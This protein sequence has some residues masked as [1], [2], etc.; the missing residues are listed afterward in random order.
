MTDNRET[1]IVEGARLDELNGTYVPSQENKSQWKNEK[2]AVITCEITDPT[3]SGWSKYK[4]KMNYHGRTYYYIEGECNL[5]VKEG[6]KKEKWGYSNPPNGERW[7]IYDTATHTLSLEHDSLRVTRRPPRDE[8]IQNM[9]EILLRNGPINSTELKRKYGLGINV[10][11]FSQPD[12]VYNQYMEA[13]D[14][15]Q[16]YWYIE[17]QVNESNL[18]AIFPELTPEQLELARRNLRDINRL[19]QEVDTMKH[20]TGGQGGGYRKRRSKR[21]SKKK[22]KSKRSKRKNK[23]KRSKRKN[24][25][26][27]RK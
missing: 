26:R 19:I 17:S 7:S 9:L 1:L 10:D 12:T 18:D 4:W 2:G 21:T 6:E 15:I 8:K 11:I 20:G 14:E 3:V 13:A 25:S 16:K 23:S 5:L 24:K 27:R 22:N